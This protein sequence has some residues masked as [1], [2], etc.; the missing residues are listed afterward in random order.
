MPLIYSCVCSLPQE[1]GWSTRGHTLKEDWLS[2]RSLQLPTA[3]QLG[4]ETHESLPPH[5]CQNRHWLDCMLVTC[6]PRRLSWV[7]DFH[8]PVMPRTHCF[9]MVLPN[10]GAYN[11]PNALWRWPWW[12]GWHKCPVCGWAHHWH[13]FSALCQAS[14]F[15][16]NSHLRSKAWGLRDTL[17]YE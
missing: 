11:L 16:I 3:P 5:P 10:A 2:P 7:D 4:A 12:R 17:L 13:V 6:R 1:P 8:S 14:S 15:C 9:S